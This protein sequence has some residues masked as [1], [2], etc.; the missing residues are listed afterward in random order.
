MIG[1]MTK[2]EEQFEMWE[3]MRQDARRRQREDRRFN[4]F[5]RRNK[6]FPAQ[7]GGEEETPEA[8]ETLIFWRGINNKQ[9]SNGWRN[10]ES[11]QEVPGK[12]EKSP[13]VQMGS[14]HRRGI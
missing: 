8:E 5:W 3:K 2:R 12:C 6:S 9:T 1:D 7:Y 4:L 13:K 11:I 14:F 10:D